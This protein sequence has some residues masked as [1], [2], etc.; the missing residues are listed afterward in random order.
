MTRISR[1]HYAALYGPTTG[2]RVRLADTNLVLRI[3]QD[4]A[5]YGEAAVLG[6]GKSIRDG[7]AQSPSAT[8]G[9][10]SPDTVITSAIIIDPVLGVVKGDIGIKNGRIAAIGKAG[11]PD[12][13]DGVDPRLVIGPGT[14]VIAGEHMIA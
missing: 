3:D 1:Q 10:G 14:E 9:S 8:A 13:M 7:M 12:I 11:N 2:D 6:G 4:S 5:A